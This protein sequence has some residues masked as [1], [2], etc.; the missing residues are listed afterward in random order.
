M[1]KVILLHYVVQIIIR[2]LVDIRHYH[3]KINFK[4]IIHILKLIKQIPLLFSLSQ[5]EKSIIL[6]I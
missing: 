2:L 5:K 1:I 6:L 3:G 4:N